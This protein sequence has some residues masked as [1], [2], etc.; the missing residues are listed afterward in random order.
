MK[1]II[2]ISIALVGILLIVFSSFGMTQELSDSD[3]VDAMLPPCTVEDGLPLVGD[4]EVTCYWGMSVE[5]LEIPKEAVAANVDVEI[6][7]EKSGVWIGIAKAS[8]ASKCEL[9]DDYYEC[10]K[11]SITMIAGG[12]DSDGEI[13]WQPEPGEYRF[14]A[15]GEDSQTLQKF[16]VSWNYQASLNSNLAIGLIIVGAVMTIAGVGLWYKIRT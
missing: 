4:D 8:E 1:K 6:T 5:V 2:A 12:P 14:V 3:V 15:G 9:K 11:D 16:D 10:P 13:I 7:W